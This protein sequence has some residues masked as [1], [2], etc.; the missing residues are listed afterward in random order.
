MNVI[1]PVFLCSQF[2]VYR[3]SCASPK[4]QCLRRG[5]TEEYLFT[6]AGFQAIYAY[7]SYV[8]EILYIMSGK[9]FYIQLT[10]CKICTQ[11]DVSLQAFVFSFH[12]LIFFHSFEA[13]KNTQ[14]TLG[15]YCVP[16]PWPSTL[17]CSSPL[18]VLPCSCLGCTFFMPRVVFLRVCTEPETAGACCFWAREQ[19]KQR[20]WRRWICNFPHPCP[21]LSVLGARPAESPAPLR[22]C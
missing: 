15:C 21:V 13:S 9:T 10:E 18:R 11:G 12:V 3:F 20:L 22:Q 17:F 16:P 5:H 1:S 2:L 14:Q 7:S 6:G 19:H 8:C 4:L